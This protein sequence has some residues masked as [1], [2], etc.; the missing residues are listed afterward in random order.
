MSLSAM[1]PIHKFKCSKKTVLYLVLLGEFIRWS[2]FWC[3]RGYCFNSA[4]KTE[5]EANPS[6]LLC[7]PCFVLYEFV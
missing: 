5:Y 7:Q 3:C 1:V 2:I 4:I 6:I